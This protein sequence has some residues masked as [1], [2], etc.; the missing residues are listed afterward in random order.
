MSEGVS[1]TGCG[2]PTDVSAAKPH[3]SVVAC[4]PRCQ[5]QATTSA[6][7]TYRHEFYGSSGHRLPCF[8]SI[9]AMSCKGPGRTRT[10]HPLPPMPHTTSSDWLCR[11]C[12]CRFGKATSESRGT[13]A[14]A[15]LIEGQAEGHLGPSWTVETCFLGTSLSAT[16]PATSLG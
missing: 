9:G 6:K 7:Y 10:E 15:E 2:R 1:C 14:E 3:E 4:C 12:H 11:P 16:T 8:R 13:Q 5:Q